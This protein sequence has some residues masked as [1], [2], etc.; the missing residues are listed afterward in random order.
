[1]NQ[2]APQGLRIRNEASKAEQVGS[3]EMTVT[4]AQ[5]SPEATERW[6]QRADILAQ[7]LATEW[8]HHQRKEAA[9]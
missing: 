1:M 4:V 3:V 6:N 8:Q 7:W 2:S 5:R 9:S